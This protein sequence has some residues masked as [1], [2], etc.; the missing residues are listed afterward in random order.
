[1]SSKDK[2]LIVLK[3]KDAVVAMLTMDPSVPLFHTTGR[4]KHKYFLLSTSDVVFLFESDLEV[5]FEFPSLGEITS[6]RSP[7]IADIISVQAVSTEEL[8]AALS[9]KGGES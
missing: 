9:F 5:N 2:L 6:R 8:A 3:H 7:T 4:G 1:L